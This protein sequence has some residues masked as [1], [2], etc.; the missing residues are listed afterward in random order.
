MEEEKRK[1]EAEQRK[2]E[3]RKARSAASKRKQSKARRQSKSK[4]SPR[5]VSA[6]SKRVVQE[7][8]PATETED[9]EGTTDDGVCEECGGCYKDESVRV[10]KTWIGCDN[11]ER[12]FHYTCIGLSEIP[13]GHW[14]C[15]YC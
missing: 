5:K 13:P 12:W 1:K 3:S 14:S 4:Y 11:C 9:S 6:R 7:T 10:R 2:Q 8:S 15:Q